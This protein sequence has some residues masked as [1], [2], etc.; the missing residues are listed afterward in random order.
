MAKFGPIDW[1]GK[2]HT[3]NESLKNTRAIVQQSPDPTKSSRFFMV[4]VPEKEV[5]HRSEGKNAGLH[6]EVTEFGGDHSRVFRRLGIDLLGVDQGQALVHAPAQRF[7]QL[8]TISASLGTAGPK[9]QAR[10]ATINA[11]MPSPKET[12]IDLDWLAQVSPSK[13]TE[14]V[15]EFQPVLDR[16][17]VD[18][19][20]TAI[21]RTLKRDSATLISAAGRDF[22]GRHW[23]KLALARKQLQTVAESFYAVQSLHHPFTSPL[24]ANSPTSKRS[25][26]KESLRLASPSGTNLASL[27]AVAV[28]DSGVPE[29]H[30]RLHPYCVGRVKHPDAAGISSG[31]HGSHVASRVVFGDFEI[32]SGT[33]PAPLGSC[34]FLDVIAPVQLMQVDDKA[35]STAI[36]MA[37]GS[38]PDVR[39][40]NCSFGHPMG[41]RTLAGIARRERLLQVQDL[42]NLICARDILVVMAA[43]NSPRGVVPAQRYPDHLDEDHWALGHWASGYNTLVCGAQVSR[44]RHEKVGIVTCAGMPSPFTRVG[45]GIAGAPVPGFS[46]EGG[47]CQDDYESAHGLGVSICGADGQWEEDCGTSLA[48]P[49]LAREAAFTLAF[50]QRFCEPS[51][52]IFA[53][54]VKAVLALFAETVPLPRNV[55]RLAAR[56]LGRGRTSARR[57]A[58][59][60]GHTAVFVWQG[61]LESPTDIVRVRLPIPL[62]WLNTAG[63]P[64]LRVVCSSDVPVS[65]AA[66]EIWATRRVSIKLHAGSEGK[67]I[68]GTKARHFSYPLIDRVWDLSRERLLDQ[69]TVVTGDDWTLTIAYAEIADSGSWQPFTPQQRVAFAAELTDESEQPVSPQAFVQ[70]LSSASTM[71]TLGTVMTRLAAPI[72]LHGRRI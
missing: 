28:L 48:A 1:G 27:P 53:C 9:E 24:A 49:L 22:S 38:Y 32:H 42:D 61:L 31:H 20:L 2:G 21:V 29:K 3:I 71:V 33:D 41:L 16:E 57:L 6:P 34:K 45:P 19:V 56:T 36:D 39:V 67:S 65:A 43:G 4:A 46:D 68:S 10:W 17:E 26:A 59:P 35:V 47:D 50:L 40:F 15:L 8:M 30:V 58:S 60:S 69:K 64:R 11:F 55:H 51:S 14:A 25:G 7:D 66:S 18:Q 13:P 54:A 62:A 5:T 70:A 52:R 37:I 23:Y 44:L 12:R 63:A 72:V